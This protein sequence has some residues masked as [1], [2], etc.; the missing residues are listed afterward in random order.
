MSKLMTDNRMLA[1]WTKYSGN[2]ARKHTHTHTFIL[3]L[4]F[5][6]FTV[7]MQYVHGIRM[8]PLT[9]FFLAADAADPNTSQSFAW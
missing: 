8:M 6:R 5:V 2:I 1:E 7:S 9:S 4:D 3:W